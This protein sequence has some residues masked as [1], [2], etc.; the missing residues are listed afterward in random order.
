MLFEASDD[1]IC[2]WPRL[3]HLTW[4]FLRTLTY[5]TPFAKEENGEDDGQMM[6]R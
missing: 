6:D 5:P 4:L 3:S 1:F 2:D